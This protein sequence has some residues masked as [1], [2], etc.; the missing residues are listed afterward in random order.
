MN[1]I[2]YQLYELMDGNE[3]PIDKNDGLNLFIY[4]KAWKLIS[5][6]FKKFDLILR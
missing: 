5:N 3:L 6:K 1:P 2:K 4:E